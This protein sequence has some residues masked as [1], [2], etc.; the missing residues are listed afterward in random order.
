MLQSILAALALLLYP[1]PALPQQ[2]EGLF[3]T[4]APLHLRIAVDLT[5]LMK[6]RDSLK[7]QPYPATLTYV[8]ADGQRI[9]IDVELKLRGD[10][11]RQGKN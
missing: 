10:W 3:D 1:H 11:R 5:A 2:A 4:K 8:G 9:S 7:L 6:E